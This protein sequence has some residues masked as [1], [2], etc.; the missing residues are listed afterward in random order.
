MQRWASVRSGLPKGGP[1]RAWGV[2]G[3]ALSG[4][5]YDGEAVDGAVLAVSELVANA[6]E[7]AVGP[8]EL[9]LRRTA[10]DV[11]CEVVDQDTRIPGDRKSVV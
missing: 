8:Y 3:Y 9:R 11:I 4:L 1:A 7:Y 10:S 6:V 5:R 2:W